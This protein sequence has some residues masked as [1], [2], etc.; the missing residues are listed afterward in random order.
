[1]YDD[2]N[3]YIWDT[4][5]PTYISANKINEIILNTVEKFETKN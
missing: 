5:H 3:I 2:K 4:V 1:M